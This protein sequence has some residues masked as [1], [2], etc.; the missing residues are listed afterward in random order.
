MKPGKFYLIILVSLFLRSTY[1]Q[2]TRHNISRIS[3]YTSFPTIAKVEPSFVELNE[4][5]K[6]LWA[7]AFGTDYRLFRVLQLSAEGNFGRIK[8]RNPVTHSSGGVELSSTFSASRFLLAGGLYMPEIHFSRINTFFSAGISY[9][10]NFESMKNHIP[11]CLDC[12]EEKTAF[13][14]DNFIEVG[15]QFFLYN[16]NLGLGGGYRYYTGPS[17]I[18]Y[19][20]IPFKIS[21]GS[22]ILKNKD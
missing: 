17:D 5:G 19:E 18:R 21:A 9:G 14:V 8:D 16:G 7:F 2:D 22:N 6:L 20:I 11:N 10:I 15:F 4:S 12:F 3:V 13:E 1:A